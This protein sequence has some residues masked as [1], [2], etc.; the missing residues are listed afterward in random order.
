MSCRYPGAIASPEDLWELIERG[1]DAISEFPLDRGWDTGGLYGPDPAR[2]GKT[3]STRGGLLT[4]VAEFAA[5][6]F[7][8][9]PR[10]AVAME[11]QQR[12]LPATS[13][14]VRARA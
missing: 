9:S 3:S 13:W 7:G 14:E 6:L 1:G 2:A 8:L 12:L 11:P 10:D 5:A 4:G